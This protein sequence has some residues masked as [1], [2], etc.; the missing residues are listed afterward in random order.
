MISTSHC[1]INFHN[2]HETDWRLS[3]TNSNRRL[4]TQIFITRYLTTENHIKLNK[5]FEQL[6]VIPAPSSSVLPSHSGHFQS[7]VSS[8]SERRRSC[9]TPVLDCGPVHSSVIPALTT[10]PPYMPLRHPRCDSLSGWQPN[11]HCNHKNITTETEMLSFWW[12]FRHWL[13]WK[14]SFWQLSVQPVTEFSSK[15]H[16]H[17]SGSQ[18]TDSGEYWN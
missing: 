13:H 10:T 6:P 11:W 12:N 5:L 16:F 17:F 7:F 9:G 1:F 3:F 14:L 2:L 18:S 15:W 4:N 8:G